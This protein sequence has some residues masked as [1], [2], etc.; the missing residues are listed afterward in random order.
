MIKR[1]NGK[2][3]KTII[4][5][6]MVAVVFLFSVGYAAFSSEFL[7]S[8]KGT[9]I[10]KP[11]TIED[12]KS[13][14]VTSGDGLYADTYESGRY[15]YRGAVPANYIT[16]NGEEAGWRIISVEA[17]GTIKIIRN[18]ILEKKAFDSDG[19][20]GSDSNGAGGTYCASS[21]YGCNAW[22]ST[23]N[24]VGTPAEFINGSVT[25]TV[26]LDAE[27]NTYLNTTY[28]NSI[29]S[30]NVV[31]HDFGVGPVTS[32]NEDLADQIADEQ[33]YKWNGKIGLMN[34]SDYL[35][36]NTNTEQCETLSL[37]N[38]NYYTCKTT[39]YLFTS[40]AADS[41]YPWTINP[42]SGLARHVFFVYDYGRVS[43]TDTTG[44]RGVAPVLYLSSEISLS[45]SGTDIDPYVIVA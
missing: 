16:F 36:A 37:N 1:R 38:S 7:I 24:L 14:V 45:G 30:T 2:K 35:R 44:V 23:T 12:L 26:L 18:S 42:Y 25:G 39:N 17:D 33:S 8:G 6:S 4:I 31:S 27:L 20:R 22:A 21:P 5:T 10:E 9:I 19:L 41:Q 11:L 28:L 34:V 29:D 13:L 15:V 32:S 3:H 40:L 43:F